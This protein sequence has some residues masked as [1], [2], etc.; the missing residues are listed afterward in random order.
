MS[1]TVRQCELDFGNT[2]SFSKANL[3]ITLDS[4]NHRFGR[5]AVSIASAG[6]PKSQRIWTMKQ[7]R[8]SLHYT[9]RWSDLP[10]VSA[11]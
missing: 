9:T 1:T 7:Q 8:L 2:D 10:I 11:D 5:D 4:L 3:M 6:L